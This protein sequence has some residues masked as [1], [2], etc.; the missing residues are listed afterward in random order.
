VIECFKTNY[1][2]S[3]IEIDLLGI[4]EHHLRT[5]A[6]QVLLDLENFETLWKKKLTT[7]ATGDLSGGQQEQTEELIAQPSAT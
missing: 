2:V 3:A 6:L 1:R 7:L 4:Y 5:T